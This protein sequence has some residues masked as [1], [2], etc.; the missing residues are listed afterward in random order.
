MHPIGAPVFQYHLLWVGTLVGGPQGLRQGHGM[1]CPAPGFAGLPT[2]I[3]NTTLTKPQHILIDI[4]GML[5]DNGIHGS[6][7]HDYS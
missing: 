7:F 3:I 2:G 4:L 5:K 1:R 6:D